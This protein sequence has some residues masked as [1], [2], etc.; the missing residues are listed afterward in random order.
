MKT[1]LIASLAILSLAYSTGGQASPG[2]NLDVSSFIDLNYPQVE[3]TYAYDFQAPVSADILSLPSDSYTANYNERYFMSIF[4]PRYKSVSSSNVGYFD[5]HKG[6]DI[7]AVVSNNGNNYDTNT[8]PTIVSRC[9]GVV[10][11]IADGS[12][13][14]MEQT[15][16]GRW[17]LV[18][19]NQKFNGNENWGSIYMAYRHLDSIDLNISIG[20]NVLSGKSIGVMGESGHTSTVHLHYSVMRHNGSKFINVNPMR[21]FSPTATEH[22]HGLLKNAEITQLHHDLNTALMRIS[23]PYQ[24]T[25][26]RALSVKLLGTDYERVYDFETISA[27]AGSQRDQNNY[28]DG[29]SL[30]AYPYNRG[31]A[32]YRRYLNYQDDM[33]LPYPA[34]PLQRASNFNPLI[35]SNLNSTPSYVLD[36]QIKDLPLDYDI[37]DLQIEL[38]DIYGYGVRTQGD[39][40]AVYSSVVFT[41]ISTGNDDA[42]ESDSGTVD[43]SSS[44]LELVND[45]SKGNQIIALR[46]PN[47]NIPVNANINHAHMQFSTDETDDGVT[48]L[49]IHAEDEDTS[50]T[51]TTEPFNL[52]QRNKT[53]TSVAWQ[54]ESWL[55]VNAVG[56]QQRTPDLTN[57]I[58][59]V[60]NRAGWTDQSALGFIISGTGKRVADSGNG[61]AYKDPY[62]YLEYNTGISGNQA[63]QIQL[64]TPLNEAVISSLNA[65]SINAEAADNDGSI[66]KVHFYVNDVEVGND[67]TAPYSYDWTPPTYGSYQLYVVAEDDQNALTASP[68]IQIHLTEHQETALL[69][70]GNDDA[71][72]HQ[73]GRIAKKGSDLELGYDSYISKNYG[74]TGQQYVGIRFP[75][76]AIAQG[77]VIS[78]AYIQF[79]STKTELDP[80]DLIIGAEAAD[81][82]IKFSYRG[83]NISNRPNTVTT[84]NWSPAPWLSSNLSGAA[85]QTPNLASLLQ[86]IINRPGWASGNAMLLSIHASGE[87]QTARTARSYNGDSNQSPRLVIE[88]S[89]TSL[90]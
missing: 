63:P 29:L 73:D 20:K 47:I 38:I 42:E 16:E 58:Q 68:S 72:Q 80:V 19:C 67:L 10:D 57:I 17:V 4:G 88:Y 54:P 7:T 87:H 3:P 2:H 21:V 35:N 83:F 13:A 44:D 37:D 69:S 71:E 45:G 50:S 34:S 27:E 64:N 12:D 36:V 56:E 82:A 46:F 1:I 65:V 75:S 77:A 23:V 90:N 31:H 26:I 61:S 53:I 60:V 15:G 78:R 55:T 33:P 9:A 81:N 14:E 5:F 39:S 85:Q 32:A 79:T 6:M 22:L 11:D 49:L 25:A 48:D 24:Q 59:P 40:T 86:E 52:S 84:I 30:F 41:P 8:P 76:V 51:L 70:N 66:T 89:N 43:L 28:V 62:L 18:R 74:L